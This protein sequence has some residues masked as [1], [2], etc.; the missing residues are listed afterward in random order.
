MIAV[1][2]SGRSPDLVA[3]LDAA[4]AG[5]AVTVAI[6]N[7]AASP[8][9][10]AADHVIDCRAGEERSVAATK[11]YVAQL[12]AGAALV[13]LAPFADLR[14]PRAAVPGILGD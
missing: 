10:A 1:S 7:D 2:Q 11:S 14:R 9:A 6:V 8:L 3:V 13:L 4:R 12:A 5:G